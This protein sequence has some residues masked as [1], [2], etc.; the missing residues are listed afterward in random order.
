MA[1]TS[2][3]RKAVHCLFISTPDSLGS[4]DSQRTLGSLGGL[5]FL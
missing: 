2:G 4:W 5:S 1:E 3:P